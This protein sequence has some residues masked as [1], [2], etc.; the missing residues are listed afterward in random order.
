MDLS[1]KRTVAGDSRI[2]LRLAATE[3]WE[4]RECPFAGCCASGSIPVVI[5][6]SVWNAIYEHGRSR[7]DVEVCGVLVGNGYRSDDQ[8]YVYVEA[9]VRGSHAE[10]GI[11]Q[12]TFTGDTWSHIH[13]VMD[14]EFPDKRIIGW[15][16]THPGFGIFLS[17]MDMFIHENFFSAH[18]QLAIVYDP[19]S[20]EEGLFVWTNGRAIPGAFQI[21]EDAE[22]LPQTQATVA[23]DK[24]AVAVMPSELAASEVSKHPKRFSWGK[25]A[26]LL[27]AILL[28][29]AL[30]WLFWPQLA[31]K[32]HGRTWGRGFP[33]AN[34]IGLEPGSEYDEAEPITAGH[35]DADK[36]VGD[37]GSSTMPDK[38]PNDAKVETHGE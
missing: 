1:D 28:L 9:I 5:R 4:R 35:S 8:P 15:Y 2:D 23:R 16:H 17:P 38:P 19:L 37:N 7:T 6:R 10:S 11:A 25:W 13:N 30:C 27:L 18:E 20:G 32:I 24:S 12:V 36:A 14:R 34:G 21:E 22:P 31:A 33:R 3:G 26:L 29:A